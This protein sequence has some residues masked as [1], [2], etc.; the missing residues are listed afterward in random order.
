[1]GKEKIFNRSFVLMLITGFLL[2]MSIMMISPIMASYA[3]SLNVTGSVLGFL[4]GVF[5]IASLII[6]PISGN[7]IDLKNKKKLLMGSIGIVTISMLGYTYTHSIGLLFFFRVLHGLGWGFASTTS[8]AIATDAI[9]HKR[10]ATGIGYYGM[11]QMLTSAIAPSI[12]LAITNRWGYQST[13]LCA[14]LLALASLS[15]TPFVLTK[16]PINSHLSLI[17]SIK[18]ENLLEQSAIMPALLTLCNAMAGASVGTFIALYAFESGIENIGLYFTVNALVMV[19]VRPLMGYLTERQGTTRVIIPCEIM[20]ALSV[21][22]LGFSKSISSILV[23]AVFMGLGNSG[24]GPA[25]IAECIH[26]TK[27]YR[28]GIATSTNYVGLDGGNFMGS[29]ISAS[30]VPLVGY[31]FM[32][33]FFALPILFSIPFYLSNK[34]KKILIN[35]KLEP[36]NLINE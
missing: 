20:I 10:L 22:G 17:K 29:M 12:G 13:F 19:L 2:F 4:T 16:S 9:P 26:S 25:L 33:S 36:L 6:R 27:R 35:E 32:F 7:A 23:V 31:G 24:A 3:T 28:R 1:M 11:M 34:K 15:M 30:L 5:S 21:I 8:M 18:L 14:S